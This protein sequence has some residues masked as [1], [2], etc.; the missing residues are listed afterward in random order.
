MSNFH[1]N[2]INRLIFF[3]LIGASVWLVFS[4]RLFQIQV[5]RA[6]KYKRKALNL[7]QQKKCIK[8]DRGIIYDRNYKKLALNQKAYSLYA[9]PSKIKKSA[10]AD[11]LICKI[12]GWKKGSFLSKIKNK[13]RQFV[14]V[15][16][17]VSNKERNQLEALKING[18]AWR[19]ENTRIYPYHKYASQTIGY[20]SIDN[21]GID[22]I[23]GSCNGLLEAGEAEATLFLDGRKESYPLFL[24]DVPPKDGKNIVLTIDIEFQSIVEEKLA[25]GVE[26]MDAISGTAVFINPH[27]GE[28]L[29]LASYPTFDPNDYNEYPTE[30][31]KNKVIT[32]QYEPGSTFKL[33][34]ASA[35]LEENLIPLTD[36]IYCEHGEYVVYK[37]HPFT[38]VHEY[39]T[40]TV[41]DV[42][43]YSS[44]IGTIKLAQK[45]G[46]KILYKYAKD[47]GFGA[48]TGI[49]FEGEVSG[50]VRKPSHW[51][52]YSIGAFPIG[53]EVAVT[54]LQMVTAYSVVANGGY[55]VRPYIIDKVI[56]P[57]GSIYLS[58][59]TS[60]IRKVLSRATVDSLVS[61]FKEVVKRGTGKEVK[62]DGFEIAGKTGTAQKSSRSGYSEHEVVASFTG[63]APAD[64]PAI[65]GIIVVDTPR[66]YHYGG[67]VAGP[68]FREIIKEILSSSN[69][70]ILTQ[71]ITTERSIANAET[72]II[73]PDLSRMFKVQAEE[74]VRSRQLNPIFVGE[75]DLVI[76]QNPEKGQHTNSGNDVYIQ[77]T[78]IEDTN[79]EVIQVPDVK[80]QSIRNAINKFAKSNVPFKV[81]GTGIVVE[82]K[83]PAGTLIAKENCCLLICKPKGKIART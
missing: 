78:P 57:D 40:L 76:A 46:S 65:M 54:A 69:Q 63:F 45:L 14:W 34:T 20:V 75:G 15:A 22:G 33:I 13:E 66:K 6:Q 16:R 39:D 42:F 9:D 7:H 44:N 82:Q 31:R 37:D 71:H 61:I 30:H 56:N 10:E 72:T 49:D 52:G 67:L 12:M 18:L 83:P 43:V 8:G 74:L 23:E 68:I 64:N 4:A 62:I 32:D 26:E 51:S 48:E 81:V 19:E 58:N 36:K 50:V 55:L 38:D 17:N 79:Q 41:K 28:I 27:T 11:A 47:F 70:T 25:F 35:L 29:A 80:G 5:I 77:L 3:L 24:E 60:T 21:C 2:S 73:V 59:N 53:Q 1:K